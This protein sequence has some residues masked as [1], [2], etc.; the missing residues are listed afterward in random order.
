MLA[1]Q[2]VWPHFH[3][4]S[5]LRSKL[6]S[7]STANGATALIGPGSDVLGFDIDTDMLMDHDWGAEIAS[8]S[9]RAGYGHCFKLS[10]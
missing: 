7:R 1:P 6:R 8:L 10:M 9:A 4:I 3:S 5:L 2:L